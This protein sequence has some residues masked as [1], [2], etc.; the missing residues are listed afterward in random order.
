ME[1]LVQVTGPL[2]RTGPLNHVQFA[3][4]GTIELITVVPP[5][6]PLGVQDIQLQGSAAW[7]LIP[8]LKV[9]IRNRNRKTL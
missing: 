3:T 5:A 1:R 2:M 9:N 6:V 7:P 8:P 4:G